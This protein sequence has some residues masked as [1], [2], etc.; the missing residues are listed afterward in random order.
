VHAR[1][2]AVAI[3][4]QTVVGVAKVL[5]PGDLHATA[6]GAVVHAERLAQQ[7]HR[8][9]GALHGIASIAFAKSICGAI[10]RKSLTAVAA[11]WR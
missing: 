8:V 6:I 11:T 1:R 5:N 7:S 10:C 4:E 2:Q 3:L 9:F